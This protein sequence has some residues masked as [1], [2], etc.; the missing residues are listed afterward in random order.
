M[1]YETSTAAF[2]ADVA[3][4]CGSSKEQGCGACLLRTQ[5]R[6]KQHSGLPTSSELRYRSKRS[7]VAVGKVVCGT[8]KNYLSGRYKP[9]FS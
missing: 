4:F 3:I 6:R 7:L 5:Q 9:P 2:L 8:F 1:E